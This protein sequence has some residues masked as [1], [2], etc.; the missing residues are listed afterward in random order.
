MSGTER[1]RVVRSL[2]LVGRSGGEV[3]QLDA[4]DRK[5]HTVPDQVNAATQAFL[6]RLCADEL[7]AEAE[8][9][10]QSVRQQFAYRRKEIALSVDLGLAR[11]ET[12]DFTLDM[13]YELEAADP[14]RYCVE[15]EL[16]RVSSRDLLE[17][18][19]FAAAVGRRFDRLRCGFA[20]AAQVEAVIDAIES[21]ETG[22]LAVDYPSDCAECSVRIE[23]LDALV[24][25]DAQLLEIRFRRLTTAADLLSA[26][27][28]MGRRISATPGLSD[29]LAL[30]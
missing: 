28:R 24:V 6:A 4:F 5:R 17:T 8:A 16:S 29:L 10:F 23:G 7:A 20:A 27:E 30:A 21:D 18:E 11:L 14:S 26:F 25:I 22:D 3:R 9:L 1:P 12:K 15:T 19:A 13:R 2:V